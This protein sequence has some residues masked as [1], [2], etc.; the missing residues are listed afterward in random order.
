[1]NT[2]GIYDHLRTQRALVKD[3]CATQEDG[4][5]TIR[6]VCVACT[7]ANEELVDDGVPCGLTGSESISH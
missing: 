6:V 3:C 5:V 1:M 2:Y 4:L 7:W